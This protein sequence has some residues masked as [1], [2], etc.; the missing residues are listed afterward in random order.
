MAEQAKEEKKP[1]MPAGARGCCCKVSQVSQ[2][3]A[4]PVAGSGGTWNCGIEARWR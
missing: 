1:V 4:E 2:S 3:G